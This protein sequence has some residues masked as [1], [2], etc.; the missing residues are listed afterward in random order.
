MNNLSGH[1]MI[2]K[3]KQIKTAL[4]SFYHYRQ[5]LGNVINH[6]GKQ[7]R[8]DSLAPMTDIDELLSKLQ[9]L[10]DNTPLM[11]E[12][13]K[14]FEKPYL[15]SE[16]PLGELVAQLRQLPQILEQEFQKIVNVKAHL[17]IADKISPVVQTLAVD[18]IEPTGK[19]FTMRPLL[20]MLINEMAT[21]WQQQA[22]I[23]DKLADTW[24]Y[25]PTARPNFKPMD[26]VTIYALDE[27]DEPLAVLNPIIITRNPQT[28]KEKPSYQYSDELQEFK[29]SKQLATQKT[30]LEQLEP[31]RQWAT[32]FVVRQNNKQIQMDLQTLEGLELLKEVVG[33]QWLNPLLMVEIALPDEQPVLCVMGYG[34]I[35]YFNG[36][37]LNKKQQINVRAFP[38][39]SDGSWQMLCEQVA[40]YEGRVIS[41]DEKKKDGSCQFLNFFGRALAGD[42]YELVI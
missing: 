23:F 28:P 29:V 16:Q 6:D 33:G 11:F 8:I 26:K 27:F 3:L 9:F 14:R 40:G 1:I 15:H 20:E 39:V 12:Q 21:L 19:L 41:S 5:A 17:I 37:A 34:Q 38:L 25:L 4:Q 24:Q 36:K 22:K 32:L 35:P 10:Q 42:E 18:D 30:L 2:E 7:W 13:M 31:Y